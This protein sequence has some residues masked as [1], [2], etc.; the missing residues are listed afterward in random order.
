ME[1][2]IKVGDW[3]VFDLKIGQI[4]EIRENGNATLSDGSFEH[5]GS[6]LDRCRPLTLRNKAITES[7]ACSYNSLKKIDGSSGFNYPRIIDHFA[8]LAVDAI[9]STDE[10]HKFYGLANEF[11]IDARNYK[12]EI[13]GVRLFRRAAND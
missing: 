5:S 12:P 13:Q 2:K 7:F 3:V 9:D 1:N 11:V 10:Q 8:Q 4:K 6:I